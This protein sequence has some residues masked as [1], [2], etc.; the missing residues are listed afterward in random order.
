MKMWALVNLDNFVLNVAVYDEDVA[1]EDLDGCRWV[2][3]STEIRKNVAGFGD[4]FVEKA[5]GYPLGLF[6]KQS[7]YPSW[8]LDENYEWEPPINQPYPDGYDDPERFFVWDEIILEW[9]EKF[10]PED[11]VPYEPTDNG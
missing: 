3:T 2:E 4:T 11:W 6:Y 8:R 1:P 5:D 10:L 7:P 9:N